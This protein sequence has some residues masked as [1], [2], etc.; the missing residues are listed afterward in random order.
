MTEIDT[1]EGTLY[2]ATVIDLVSRRLLGCSATL[3]ASVTTPS[4]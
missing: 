1:G 4:R 2:F 3:W